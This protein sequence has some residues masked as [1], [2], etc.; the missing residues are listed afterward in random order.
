MTM[1]HEDHVELDKAAR[2]MLRA[3]WVRAMNNEIV[4][5]EVKA[6][7]L[8]CVALAVAKHKF[9]DVAPFAGWQHA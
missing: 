6:L 2:E 5:D 3:L 9:D 7:R 4:E 1:Q 8:G